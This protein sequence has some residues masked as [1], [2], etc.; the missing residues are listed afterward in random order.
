MASTSRQN[1]NVIVVRPNINVFVKKA[2][3]NYHVPVRVLIDFGSKYTF[4]RHSIAK[5]NNLV[6]LDDETRLVSNWYRYYKMSIFFSMA[7]DIMIDG[8]SPGPMSVIVVPDKYLKYEILVGRDWLG[9]PSIDFQK[10]RNKF[11]VS[12]RDS[13]FSG[14]T[15]PPMPICKK[16]VKIGGY[17]IC[18]T[19]DTSS[20]YTLLKNKIVS[21]WNLDKQRF[22][23]V[24]N[25]YEKWKIVIRARAKTQIQIDGIVL[26]TYVY[27][28][29]NMIPDGIIGNMLLSNSRLRFHKKANKI[30]FARNST[31]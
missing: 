13:S 30:V 3:L 22:F 21:K 12:C 24:I 20:Y 8:I 29:D 9:Q 16:N 18:M 5:S 17:S 23:K 11:L 6:L 10:T 14:I 2:I 26:E 1:N 4:I 31:V 7:A 28:V 27:I 15:V 19:I 25:G